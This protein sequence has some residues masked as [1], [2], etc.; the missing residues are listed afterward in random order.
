M[1]GSPRIPWSRRWTSWA[2]DGWYRYV[3]RLIAERGIAF[4]NY[5]YAELDPRVAPLTLEAVDE[6]ERPCI[7]LYD[8]VARA[9]PLEGRDVLEVSSGHGGGASYVMRYL[10]PR[11]LLGIDRNPRAIEF[12]ERS[13]SIPG[14]R[15]RHGTAEALPVA[16]ASFDVVINVEA[17]HGYADVE[18]F[19]AE[20]ARVLRRGGSFLFAD[21]RGSG[22]RGRLRDAFARSGLELLREEDITPNVVRALEL[23]SDGR[24]TLLRELAPPIVRPLLR[25]FAGIRGSRVYREFREGR[26]VYLACV[27]RKAVISCDADACGCRPSA[28]G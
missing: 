2:W 21:F 4:L 20:V 26:A 7:Q 10:G 14:L 23:M 19:L 11:S 17:S 22:S 28:S 1:A 25:Q 18:R 3:S 6:P 12:C 27:L 5:G 13:V 8:R 16:D 9:I 15:F 24:A